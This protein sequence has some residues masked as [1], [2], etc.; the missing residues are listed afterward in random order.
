MSTN[1]SW[2]YIP[3][4]IFKCVAHHSVLLNNFCIWMLLT[5]HVLFFQSY[6]VYL[7]SHS[8]GPNPSSIDVES[9]TMSHYDLLES[10]VGRYIEFNPKFM[11][12]SDVK[13]NIFLCLWFLFLF[14]YA[15]GGKININ[16]FFFSYAA[17]P[18][19]PKKQSFILTRDILMVLLQY[20]MKMKQRMFQ[21]CNLTSCIYP[22]HKHMF[23]VSAILKIFFISIVFI[24]T[25]NQTLGIYVW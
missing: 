24:G 11:K 16:W 4:Y 25:I 5:L 1:F 15:Y 9:V 14:F 12:F 8:F 21:V 6:I 18:E 22:I 7:G 3:D 19:R 10:Y 23:Q 20:L 17:A 2:R 13:T